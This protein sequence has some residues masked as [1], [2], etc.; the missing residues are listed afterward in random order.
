MS[1]RPRQH[2]PGG[3][4]H[5]TLRG[6]DQQAIF[7]DEWD[8]QRLEELV[9]E[10]CERYGIRVHAFCWMSNHIHLAIQVGATT[11]GD[12]MRWTASR[13]AR[14]FNR[15]YS[16]CGHVFEQRYWSKLAEDDAY[17]LALVRYIHLNPVDAKAVIKPES[18]RWSSH[19]AYLGK[20]DVPWLSTSLILSI[21]GNDESTS[22]AQLARMVAEPKNPG[23]EWTAEFNTAHNRN[24]HSHRLIVG[25]NVE[26]GAVAR[27]NA[28][29]D[30]HC[31]RF[32][33]SSHELTSRSRT[34]RL[35]KA[36]AII[37]RDAIDNGIATLAEISRRYGRSES[38]VLRTMNR[39][40]NKTPESSE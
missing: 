3:I 11:L 21:F 30:E 6:N 15:R 22:R 1:R 27:L 2:V 39:Y 38:V 12:F 13:Y 31:R 9:S 29:I 24:R 25:P 36:R 7:V 33:I 19:R 35:A 23:K 37:A 4:Y 10:G 20:A 40:R 5:V 32:G 26:S 34:R 8:F 18:Y 16:R 14:G 17:L 28:L